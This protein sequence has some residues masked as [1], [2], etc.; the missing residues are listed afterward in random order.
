MYQ[1]DENVAVSARHI[2]KMREHIAKAGHGA[3]N[4][5]YDKIIEV[6]R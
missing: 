3:F 5:K 1:I 6:Y 4:F 2:T